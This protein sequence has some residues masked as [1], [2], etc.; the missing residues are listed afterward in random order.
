MVSTPL[1]NTSQWDD[2]P[3]Y[4]GK[5][6][7]LKPPT[8]YYIP[9][10][11]PLWISHVPQ[12]QPV[13]H[14]TCETAPLMKATSSRRPCWR[15]WKEPLIGGLIPPE[16]WWSSSD[17]IIIPTLGDIFSKCS[18]PL[19]RIWVFPFWLFRIPGSWS[20]WLATPWKKKTENNC[21]TGIF[22]AYHN[23]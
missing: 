5:K 20:L 7:W 19:T 8:R 13:I 16:K 17:W 21:N 1:K 23:Q 15:A 11:H 9:T 22:L 4:Y 14:L 3:I 2:Y 12:G 6:I 18:K 10:H